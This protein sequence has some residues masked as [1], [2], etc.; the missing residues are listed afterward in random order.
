MRII[1]LTGMVV[2]MIVMV[3]MSMS[4]PMA[5]FLILIVAARSALMLIS[6][7]CLLCDFLLCF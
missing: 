5:T 1:A 6:G 3:T 7:Q 4:V 2:T